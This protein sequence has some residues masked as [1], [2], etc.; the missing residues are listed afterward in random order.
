[1]TTRKWRHSA[2]SKK[3]QNVSI[4]ISQGGFVMLAVV[5][6]MVLV[7]AITLMLTTESTMEANLTS[8]ANEALEVEYLVEAALQHAIWQNDANVCS[9][10]FSVPSTSLGAHSYAATVTG[11]GTT[12]AYSLTV[13]QDAWIRNDQPTTNNGAAA[14]QHIRFESGNV[15]QALYRFD[16]SSL[17]AGAQINSASASFYVGVGGMGD[18]PHPEGPLTV[19][20][21][22]TDWAEGDATWDT[23][24]G[25]FDAQV[26]GMIPPQ[27]ASGAQVQVNL[28]AQVQAWVNG[29]PNYGVLLGSTA[30]GV[31]AHY[32]S[33]EGAASERPRLDVVVGGGA[34][35][36]VSITATG[37]LANGITRTLSRPLTSAYQSPGTVTLQLGTDPG[38]DTLLDDFYPRNYGGA[39]NLLVNGDP[40][41]LQRPLLKFD[42]G[43]VPARASVL[44]ARLELSLMSVAA[45]GAAT[46]HRVTRSWIEGTKN[47]GG[48]ADGATWATYDGSNTWTSAGGDFNSSAVAE[49]A[50]DSSD[51]WVSWEIGPLVEQ[52]LAGAPNDGLLIQADGALRQAKFATRENSNIGVQPK[53]TITYACEC[54]S[55]CLAPQG[56]GNVL[57]V[58]ADPTIVDPRDAF[59]KSLFETWGYTVN[60]QND[61][62]GQTSYDSKFA[63]N[64]VVYVS[65]TAI[66]TTVGTKLT[67]TSIGVVSANGELN[68]E[69]GI[70][71]G[72]A[73]PVGSTINISDNSHYITLPFAAGPLNVYAAAMEGLA[74]GGAP[75]P[76]LQTLA[77]WSGAGGLAALDAGAATSGGGTAAGRRVL[78]PIGAGID[79]SHVNNNGRLIMQRALAWGTGNTGPVTADP[80]ILSTDSPAILGGLSFTDTDFAEYDPGTSAASLYFNGS[81]T[82]LNTDI[83]A[84]HVLANGHIVL[85]AKGPFTLLGGVFFLPGDLVDYDPVADTA[86]KIFNGLSLFTDPSERIISVH[87]LDN[88]HLVLS[89]DSDATLGGLSFTDV[90]LVEYDPSTDTATLF[91]DGSLTTLNKD[92]TAVHVLANGHLVLAANGNPDTTLGS[93]TFQAGD[94]VDYD[95]VADSA[96]LIFDGDALFTDP[97]EIIISAHVGPGSGDLA[98]G[99]IPLAH[100]KLDDGAGPT[101]IDSVGSHDGALV[102]APGWVAGTIDGGLDFDGIDD[103]VDAGTFDV[104]GTGLT[105]MGW[106]NAET[107]P[108][109]DGRI[110]SKANGPNATDAWWQLSTTDSGSNR[111]IRMRIKAGGTTTTFAD[112]SVNLAPARWYFAVGTYDNATGA[113]KLYLDG[114]EVAS[115]SHAVGGPVDTDPAVPVAIG[116]NGTAERFFDGILDDVRIYDRAMDATEITD[117]FAAGGGGGGGGGGTCDGTFRD[118]FDAI[119]FSGSDGTLPWAGDWLEV[120]ES[121]GAASGDIRVLSDLSSNRLR[122]RDNDSGGEGVEREADLSGAVSA[123][124]SYD[125]RRMNLDSSSDYTAVEV[126]ANGAAGPWT[127]LTRHQGWGTDGNYVPTSHDISGFASANT[128]IRFKT[129]SSMGGTDTVWF[130]NIQ[131]LCAP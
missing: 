127:E 79:L 49:T 21:V 28:T 14:T 78:L 4:S 85:A 56:S 33:K 101:A 93:V 35:W 58:V 34:V 53:L 123:T 99:I 88:G 43:T 129:S 42:L 117:L 45:P 51:T 12:S 106:F 46:A 50:I 71:A 128:R 108:T 3:K 27:S 109:S 66:A 75:A 54:G 83:T 39:D 112:S 107:I 86:T 61:G 25:N 98:G 30:E 48:V 18:G 92:I 89:T 116:A 63:T 36:P 130:D 131:I 68:D 102:S 44:S 81:V 100:W 105:M 95:P 47:G 103:L 67:N 7:A 64:D 97:A 110:V 104:S 24:N 119:S 23:M 90:D 111:Y 29:Q 8:R 72:S 59:K 17:P 26:L 38:A 124:L 52:W 91:F 19:H 22:T 31:H 11:G 1:M 122:T 70:A 37:T 60:L 74:V 84:A 41:W 80:L 9:G 65:E 15:E 125:Y 10:D 114:A 40:A 16:L 96:T 32:V 62:A 94:L 20:R 13:D 73:S 57:L 2:F 126:S 76:G 82:T 87:V 55:A 69:L 120:G 121:S 118:N 113:M 115:A 5:V 6:A 77:D